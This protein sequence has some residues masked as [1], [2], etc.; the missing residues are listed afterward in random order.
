MGCAVPESNVRERPSVV[1]WITGVAGTPAVRSV[2]F[3]WICASDYAVES[4]LSLSGKG[5]P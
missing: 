2:S 1:F 5:S 4:S 3:P